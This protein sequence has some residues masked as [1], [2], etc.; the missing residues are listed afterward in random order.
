MAER[1]LKTDVSIGITW[2]VLLSVLLPVGFFLLRACERRF[3]P[4]PRPEAKPIVISPPAVPPTLSFGDA[5]G[6]KFD[7]RQVGKSFILA[8]GEHTE[9]FEMPEG[10]AY[11]E[12][13]VD[14]T[15]TTDRRKSSGEL[16][17]GIPTTV[18]NGAFNAHA[19][20]F[21]NTTGKDVGGRVMAWF[22]RGRESSES[23]ASN[24]AREPKVT[25]RQA[26]QEVEPE[27][28]EVDLKARCGERKTIVQPHTS[29]EYPDSI[30]G[31]TILLPPTGCI[32]EWY[33]PPEGHKP[34]A[35]DADGGINFQFNYPNTMGGEFLL[36]GGGRYTYSPSEE[37]QTAV[38]FKNWGT[39]PVLVKV[40]YYDK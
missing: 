8:P 25:E 36:Q 21:H 22:P 6:Q 38:R 33:V 16:A 4:P 2:L 9:W 7:K 29:P 23:S 37:R 27:K 35:F 14:D 26:R 11:L 19:I 10:A 30:V 15:L 32:T 31:V 18:G 5:P 34:Y 40:M 24:R 20:R 3:A 28:I 12:W 17:E 13:L 39:K 1:E